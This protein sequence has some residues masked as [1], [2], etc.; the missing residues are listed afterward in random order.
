MK[1]LTVHNSITFPP[2]AG[3]ALEI[4]RG[5]LAGAE[6]FKA[7]DT[8][9]PD[10]DDI[11]S[12]ANW[13][14]YGWATDLGYTEF[15]QMLIDDF[16]GSWVTLTAADHKILMRCYVWPSGTPDTELDALWTATER[17]QFLANATARYLDEQPKAAGIVPH[18]ATTLK[19][20][21]TVQILHGEKSCTAIAPAWME[22]GSTVGTPEN[23]VADLT[24]AL[25]RF[26]ADYK[27]SGTGCKVRFIEE[28]DGEA[29]V[30]LKTANMPNT[31]GVYKRDASVDT[32]PGVT[33]FRSG[34]NR[35]IIEMQRPNA[36]V[37][38]SLRD[39][40]LHLLKKN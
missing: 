18:T 16:V 36:G 32:D 37:T 5:A 38:A 19:R 14:L 30:T 13:E 21:I 33:P 15:R 17:A 24:K 34:R 29:D 4:D 20:M 22:M 8:V 23:E 31:S 26:V 2:A 35:F 28:K 6:P 10:Y 9:S 1:K 7:E 40:N 27:T 12:L 39:I 11:T 3:S 25:G